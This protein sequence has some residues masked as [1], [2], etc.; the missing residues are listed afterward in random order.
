VSAADAGSG[1]ELL[2]VDVE[3]RDGVVVVH[4]AG[5]LDYPAKDLLLAELDE[6]TSDAEPLVVD[7]SSVT[8]IDSSGL[9]ALIRANKQMQ[10]P[11]G[12]LAVVCVPGGRV[13]HLIHLTGLH[14]VL[15]LYDTVDQAV[16]AERT[17]RAS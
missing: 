8:F 14:Q 13:S 9:G 4:V 5:E 11:R 10:R 12:P 1:R 17:N 6:W 3:R 7:L 15:R 16:S 2:D